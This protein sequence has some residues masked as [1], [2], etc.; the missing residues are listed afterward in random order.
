M[1][2]TNQLN[3]TRY[4]L[5]APIYDIVTRPLRRSR[6]RAIE[7]L[8]LDAGDRVLIPGCG[9]GEDLK[10]LP[11]DV[12]VVALD[13]TP[14][15]VR[16][17]AKRA[18]SLDVN[19]TVLLGDAHQLPVA[20]DTFDAVL[21]HLVLSVVPEP[22]QLLTEGARVTA[23]EGRVSIFDKFAPTGAAPS[24]VRRAINPFA[25][26]VFSDLNRR[27]D[28]LVAGSGLSLLSRESVLADLYTVTQATPGSAATDAE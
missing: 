19:A 1:R 14:A 18:S 25:R 22:R 10:Y 27:L 3:R 21:L 17:T 16:R 7:R 26:L 13:L 28:P 9:T 24:I 2:Q 4:Q 11:P 15:M 23:P 8:D 5:Y 20:N 6:R 12:E